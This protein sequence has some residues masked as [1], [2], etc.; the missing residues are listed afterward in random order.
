MHVALRV[1]CMHVLLTVTS[2]HIS[3]TVLCMHVVLSVVHACDSECECFCYRVAVPYLLDIATNS[4]EG[5]LV[6]GMAIHRHC[7]SH[8]STCIPNK[9]TDQEEPPCC[10]CQEC[11]MLCAVPLHIPQH[12]TGCDVSSTA[13]LRERCSQKSFLSHRAQRKEP[14]T[15]QYAWRAQTCS[16]CT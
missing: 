10:Q 8:L 15:S 13:Q 11:L 14:T 4:G 2:M 3:L 16:T 12:K 6:L 1:L 7:A 9:E 5:L